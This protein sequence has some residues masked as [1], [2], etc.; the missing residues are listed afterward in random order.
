[1]LEAV[2]QRF[3]GDSSVRVVAHNIDETLPALW[4]L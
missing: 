1:M 2:R 3:A 4:E